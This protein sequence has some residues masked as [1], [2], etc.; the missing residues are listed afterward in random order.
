[1]TIELTERERVFI[2]LGL[3]QIRDLDEKMRVEIAR[4]QIRLDPD[5]SIFRE[6]KKVREERHREFN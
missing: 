1:M 3:E 6:Q 2:W 5:W 4:I